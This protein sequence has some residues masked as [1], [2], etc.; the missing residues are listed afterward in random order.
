M[1]FQ[2]QKT[3][4]RSFEPYSVMDILDLVKIYIY[5]RKCM[6]WRR[7]EMHDTLRYEEMYKRT[8]AFVK[9]LRDIGD[10][11]AGPCVPKPLKGSQ[12]E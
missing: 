12:Y 3:I 8:R 11:M 5:N 4:V 6:A 10:Y 9:S 1:E 7:G 2:E